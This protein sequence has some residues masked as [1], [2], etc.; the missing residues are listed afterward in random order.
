MPETLGRTQGERAMAAEP[1][2]EERCAAELA[3]VPGIGEETAMALAL[4][5][6]LGGRRHE[7]LASLRAWARAGEHAAQLQ[8]FLLHRCRKSGAPQICGMVALHGVR[9][10]A[11]TWAVLLWWAA[12]AEHAVQLLQA[13]CCPGVPI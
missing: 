13:S 2:P 12:S 5:R 1:S 11:C 7:G 8:A 3:A 9:P 10:A 4:T 6:A